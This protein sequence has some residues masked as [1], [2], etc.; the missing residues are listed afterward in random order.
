MLFLP[1]IFA[2]NN[3]S[4]KLKKKSVQIYY[5]QDDF[6]ISW[7]ENAALFLVC[8]FSILGFCRYLVT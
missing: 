2:L 8:L 6:Y 4:F 3:Q 5:Y 7:L 1:W